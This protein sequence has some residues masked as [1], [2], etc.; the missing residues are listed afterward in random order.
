LQWQGLKPGAQDAGGQEN[1]IDDVIN[2]GAAWE[3]SAVVADQGVVTSRNPGDLAAFS[4]KIVEE[5][6][7][8]SHSRRSAA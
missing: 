4:K 8:S 1:P 7:E 2:A 5:L 3:D 6:N